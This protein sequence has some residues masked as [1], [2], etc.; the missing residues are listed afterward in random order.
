VSVTFTINNYPGSVRELSFVGKISSSGDFE[1]IKNK[2]DELIDLGIR[3]F[4]LNLE[5]VSFMNSSGLNLMLNLL[6][7]TRNKGG[8]L[9]LVNLNGTVEKLF[10]ISKLKKVFKICRSLDEAI[11]E[12]NN[13]NNE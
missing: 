8:D 9:I 4:I 11:N 6:T 13:L 7:K 2:V 3:K 5:G 12:L 10:E 1:E